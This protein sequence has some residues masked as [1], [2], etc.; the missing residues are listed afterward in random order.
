MVIFC[1]RLKW[2]KIV[3]LIGSLEVAIASFI[4]AFTAV[5]K[6]KGK[7]G[8]CLLP[9]VSKLNSRCFCSRT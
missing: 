8:I 7:I 6:T 3:A 4:S 1:N 5:P 9:S 2:R